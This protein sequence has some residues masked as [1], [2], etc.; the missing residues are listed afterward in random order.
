MVYKN[1]DKNQESASDG[2]RSEL[3]NAPKNKFL[4]E[5]QGPKVSRSIQKAGTFLKTSLPAKLK[6]QVIL[7]YLATGTRYRT[8]S[9]L[10]RVP[11][12]SISLMIPEVCKAICEVLDEFIKDFSMILFAIIDSNYNFLY[13]DV[14]TNGRAN[15]AIIFAK[16]AFNEALQQNLPNIPA[17]GIFLSDDAF[18][19]RTN[20]LKPYSRATSLNDSFGFQLPTFKRSKSC[21]K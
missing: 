10:D 9:A 8:L 12:C 18:P 21:R 16:S 7:H 14:D 2:T 13:I 19:L 1:R 20:I 5:D 17:E 15:D 6:L 11:A 4:Y 3:P